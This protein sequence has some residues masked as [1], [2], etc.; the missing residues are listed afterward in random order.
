MVCFS[1]MEGGEYIVNHRATEQHM[2]RLREINEDGHRLPQ[3]VGVDRA[4]AGCFRIINTVAVPYNRAMWIDPRG[5]FIVNR[6]A[7]AR[8]FDELQRINESVTDFAQCDF[9]ILRPQ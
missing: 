9:A 1:N 8:H 7:T 5:Q 6:A 3:P 2:Q 4:P